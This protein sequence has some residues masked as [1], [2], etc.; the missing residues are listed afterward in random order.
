MS[1]VSSASERERLILAHLPQVHLLAG[2]LHR[3][4]PRCVEMDDLISVGIVGLMQAVDRFQPERGLKLKTLAEHRIRGA[5]AD[6]LR[7]LDPLSRQV[8][9][10]VRQREAMIALLTAQLGRQPEN[11]EL[12]DALGL[13]TE[14]YRRFEVR[15]RAAQIVSLESMTTRGWDIAS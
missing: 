13:S 8:R 11:A 6:Y 10:F 3:H 2:R 9:R 4:C 5:M 12:A 15:A 7:T 1:V 14:R